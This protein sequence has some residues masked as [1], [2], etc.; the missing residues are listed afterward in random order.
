[1]TYASIFVIKIV[2]WNS[3]TWIKTD[4]CNNLPEG[5]FA[6]NCRTFLNGNTISPYGA[7]S[8]VIAL[9]IVIDISLVAITPLIPPKM[10]DPSSTTALARN[11]A[12]V[13]IYLSGKASDSDQSYSYCASRNKFLILKSR[14]PLLIHILLIVASHT[15]YSQVSREGAAALGTNLNT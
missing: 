12:T 3:M 7:N 6:C 9:A 10:S 8:P 2:L 13:G 5:G 15:I 14:R 4:N 1:M 11:H